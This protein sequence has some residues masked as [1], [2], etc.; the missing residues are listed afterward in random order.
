MD[1]GLKPEKLNL[2]AQSP[3]ATEIFK[4][5]LRC[6]E[7]YLNSSETEVDGPRKLSL[8]HARVGHRLSSVIEEATTS[9]TA[10]EILQKCFVTPINEVHARYLLSTCRQRSG[11]TLDEYLERLTALTRNCDHKEVT[12]EVHMNT[13]RRTSKAR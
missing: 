7:A 12:A 3:E 8:L 6:F 5:W 13:E 1:S 4:Y 10:V 9:E 2:D 11:E